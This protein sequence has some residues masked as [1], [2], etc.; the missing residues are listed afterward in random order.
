VDLIHHIKEGKIT[1]KIA[2]TLINE[3]MDGTT[4]SK[5]VEK[6][7]KKRISNEKILEN[8]CVGVIKNYPKIVED[9]RKNPKAIEALIGRVMG[10]T[11]GQADPGITREIMIKLLRQKEI[12][13]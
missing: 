1:T 7:G 6:N 13:D 4:I 8:H 9:C 2:K 10:K 3:M 11:K 12:I 5:I